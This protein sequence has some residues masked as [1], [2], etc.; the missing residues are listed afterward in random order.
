MCG[1]T[2]L[3]AMGRILFGGVIMLTAVGSSPGQPAAGKKAQALDRFKQLDR[4]GDG[5][6][7][8]E[9]L[10]RPELFKEIDKDGDGFVTPEEIRGYFVGLETG[11]AVKANPNLALP[12]VPPMAKSLDVPYAKIEGVAPKLLSLDIYA[13]S[14][15]VAVASPSAPRAGEEGEKPAGKAQ[16]KG[17]RNGPVMVYVHGGA[18]SAGDKA[19]VGCKPA[20]FVGKGWVFIS[21]NY[22]LFP[23]G[24][25]PVNVEDVARA[26]AWVHGHVGEYGGDPNAI[27]LMGHSAGAHLAALA[28]TDGRR[29][30][31]AV[32]PTGAGAD[33]TILKGVVLGDSNAY[34][35]SHLM[36]LLGGFGTT[37]DRVFG[38]D[39]AVW[40]DASPAAFVA[41][42][43]SIP[44]FL[45]LHA[46]LPSR[47]AQ[48]ENLAKLL[49]EAGVR[50]EIFAAPD[51][52]HGTLNADI[53]KTGDAP[54]KAMMGF[55]DSIAG[56]SR[57]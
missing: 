39:P 47:T 28:A 38:G 20:F 13:S 26:L 12:P 45:L 5:K 25:H 23:A 44:P 37:Y 33:L 56:K 40:K 36:A 30:K 6:L 29:L 48:A 49:K 50:A 4:N 41:K 22:R 31:A 57:L 34:D 21:V 42:G 9:E 51:K 32:G 7:T 15:S 55:L 16:G 8:A 27:F 54:T 14:Q 1:R 43:K 52:N 53:G 2:N 18:W 35:V 19:G 46:G 17:Q 3:M 10:N 24:K 11:P